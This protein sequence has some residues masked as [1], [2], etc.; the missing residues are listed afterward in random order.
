MNA[1]IS[2]FYSIVVATAHVDE[3]TFQSSTDPMVEP[4]HIFS[5]IFT[6][7]LNFIGE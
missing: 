4:E 5:S 6:K 7:F 2:F 1:N 3:V